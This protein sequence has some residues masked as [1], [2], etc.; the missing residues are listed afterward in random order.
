MLS[1]SD[2]EREQRLK[3]HYENTVQQLSSQLRL[4]DS[5]ALD[6]YHRQQKLE[7][8]VKQAKEERDVMQKRLSSATEKTHTMEKSEREVRE[9]YETQ[10]QTLTEHILKVSE[11]SARYKEELEHSRQP[12]QPRR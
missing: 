10:I 6:L 1:P 3:A 12:T 4:A 11:M 7:K 8:L 5:K 9:Q 2:I